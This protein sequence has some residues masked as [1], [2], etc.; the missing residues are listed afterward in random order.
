VERTNGQ[1]TNAAG[2]AND[3]VRRQFE[4][5][6]LP[7]LAVVYRSAF[8]FTGRVEDARDVTQE[9]YLR[10][11]RT[12]DRFQPGTNCKAWLLTIAYSVFVNRYRRQQRDPVVAVEDV[13]RISD[14]STTGVSSSAVSAVSV[15]STAAA[16]GGFAGLTISDPEI[17]EALSGLPETFRAA[18]LLVDV[19]ELTYEEAAEVLGCPVN[20]VRSRLSRGRKLLWT[21]LRDYANRR[22]YPA[23]GAAR[24]QS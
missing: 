22:G 8:R 3:E 10:A 17:G 20:T 23:T 24:G 14:A 6:A 19:E 12:F 1:E 13:E 18:V 16:D 9:T 7:L 21:A 2:R 15:E 4:A 5:V 11:F